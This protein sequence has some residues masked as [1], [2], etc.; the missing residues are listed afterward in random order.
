MDTT[1]AEGGGFT[2]PF[3]VVTHSCPSITL[4]VL[5]TVLLMIIF[6]RHII[7]EAVITGHTQRADPVAARVLLATL[8]KAEP[9]LLPGKGLLFL[10]LPPPQTLEWTRA[11]AMQ[12]AGPVLVD[13]PPKDRLAL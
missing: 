12:G 13:V 7:T 10:D 9:V 5:H 6:I 4:L 8:R 11:E 3:T 2:I 1:I